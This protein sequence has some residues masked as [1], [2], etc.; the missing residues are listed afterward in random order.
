MECE[1]GWE[2]V[3]GRLG[4]NISKLVLAI[5]DRSCISLINFFN[6]FVDI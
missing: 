5:H 3:N 6:H 1:W 2:E 4:L